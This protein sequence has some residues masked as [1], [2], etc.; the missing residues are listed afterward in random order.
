[1]KP[2]LID[3]F[4]YVTENSSENRRKKGSK[5]SS[6]SISTWEM[7]N[8]V[9]QLKQ[10]RFRGTTKKNYYSV[11]KMFNQFIIRLDIKPN[12]WEDRKIL[13]VSYLIKEGKKSTTIKSHVS[14]IRA[15]LMNIGYELNENKFLLNSMTRAGKLVDT[16]VRTRF[17]I[18]KGM[19]KV[20]NHG[21]TVLFE[22]QPYLCTL[23]FT[24]F[25]TAYFGLFRISEIA[26]GEHPVLAHDV[27]FGL[28]KKKLLF[29]LQSSKTHGHDS[30]PQTVKITSAPLHNRAK[31]QNKR[32]LCP[33]AIIQHYLQI[34]PKPRSEDELF[35]VFRDNEPV[36]P[37]HFRKVLK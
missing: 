28:N 13:F 4:H 5:S 7:T 9:E 36:R 1:M 35:F 37:Y 31:H 30:K 25:T 29:L 6:S 24:M 17:P 27:H 2:Q 20:L 14:A 22:T 11:W 26:K 18:K 10:G 15:M 12:N 19:L 34:R 8:L 33:Y 32:V 3:V 23:Y 21:L 16:H